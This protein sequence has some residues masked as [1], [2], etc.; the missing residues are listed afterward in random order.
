MRRP[1]N[2]IGYVIQATAPQIVRKVTSDGLKSFIP[3]TLR[4]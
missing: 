2:G 4:A 1:P 3:Q